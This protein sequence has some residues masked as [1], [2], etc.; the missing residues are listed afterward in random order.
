MNLLELCKQSRM[1]I[2]ALQSSTGKQRNDALYAMAD[3]F[4]QDT[5]LILQANSRDL[6]NAK[7]NGVPPQMVD[8]LTLTESRLVSIADAIRE[9][10]ALPDPLGLGEE[11]VRPN[12]LVI[13]RRS[14][15]IGLIAMI[16]EARPNVTADAAALAVKS[17]NC[18]VLRGG[19]EAFHTNCAMVNALQKALVSAGLPET[20]VVM[21][22]DTSRETAT[23]LMK[24]R[25]VVDL[26]IPRGGKNLIRSVVENASVPVIET[27]AGNCHVYVDESA[28]FHIALSVTDNA[29]RQRPS[30][31]NAA[32]GL[33][34]HRA[35]AGEFLPLLRTRLENVE[36][37]GCAETCAI[38]PDCIPATDEDFYTEY[39]DL[40]L[41]IKVVADVDEAITWI[42]K[43]NTGHSE[44]IITRDI[45]SANRFTQGIDASAVYVNASTRF[46][47]GGEFGFG[48]EIGISTQKMHARGP[49]GLSALTTVKY[50]V[51]GNG[52]IRT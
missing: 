6:A 44:A 38:L 50:V 13:R 31:C 29:K 42:N 36:F 16:Y 41:H 20:C 2:P 8:R 37:R 28:D 14:V 51:E 27:G 47:D 9:V 25:G 40:I 1:A 35:V 11:W 12:G 5:E 49:M 32:E 22:E 33:L 21:P 24:L 4:L 39:N 23:Q 43:H 34:V 52:Q 46:T 48:A 30:V 26:L 45:A 10:A 3:A 17:G 18:V 15:P 7:E 19:K